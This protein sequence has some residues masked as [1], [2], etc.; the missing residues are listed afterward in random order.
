MA[1]GMYRYCNLQEIVFDLYSHFRSFFV[2]LWRLIV[3]FWG[4]NSVVSST[5]DWLEWIQ[6]CSHGHF[7]WNRFLSL[8]LSKLRL[9]SANHRTW[10]FSNL[11]CDWLSI[12]W[13]YSEQETEHRPCTRHMHCPL[14]LF[15]GL[16]L[17]GIRYVVY[18]CSKSTFH[19][20]LII[21]N[22][23]LILLNAHTVRA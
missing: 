3:L 15:Q 18:T 12:V 19:F 5:G 8:T 1:Q 22:W 6:C 9:C 21:G 10:Y 11:A 14:P 2:L 4:R 17:C 23:L 7:N 20:C 16:W 13:A